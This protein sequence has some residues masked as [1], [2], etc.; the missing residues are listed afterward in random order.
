MSCGI[1]EVFMFYSTTVR[2][3]ASFMFE[4]SLLPEDWYPFLFNI[5]LSFW[6]LTNDDGV[7]SFA[8]SSQ[9]RGKLLHIRN[10]HLR[11]HRGLLPLIHFSVSL[12]GV[13]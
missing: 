1:R 10:Q 13:E 12:E 3:A 8:N 6:S 5:R 2:M 7:A 9:T 4:Q 11:N